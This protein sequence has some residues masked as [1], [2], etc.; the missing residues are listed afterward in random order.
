MFENWKSLI[1]ADFAADS[2]VWIYQSSRF[3]SLT[4][5]LQIEGILED[6]VEHWQSHGA[7][8]K[9]YANL[10]FGQFVLFMADESA[11]GVSGCSTDSSVRVIK[12]IEKLYGVNMFDRQTLGFIRKEKV[13]L[14]PISQFSYAMDAG[15]INADTP[16]FNNLVATKKDLLENWIIPVRSS[17]LAKRFPLLNPDFA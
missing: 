5:A 17:W 3:F 7:K 2:R 9:G 13:E 6:F 14:I 10:F 12:E 16:Y 4:E 11:A 15:L 8:V 1:P